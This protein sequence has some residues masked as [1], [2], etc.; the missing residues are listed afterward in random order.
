MVAHTTLSRRTLLA[1]GG[2][3]TAALMTGCSSSL[4]NPPPTSPFVIGPFQTNSV[5]LGE[6][7][8]TQGMPQ[9]FGPGDLPDPVA[10]GNAEGYNRVCE[11]APSNTYEPAPLPVSVKAAV[12]Y[13]TYAGTAQP[14][15]ASNPLHMAPGPFPVLL[16]AHGWR[17]TIEVCNSPIP[18]HRDFTTAQLML[19]HVASYG[20]V[21]IA[22]DLSWL[23]T[24]SLFE[25]SATPDDTAL[26]RAKVLIAYFLYLRDTLNGTLFANQLDLSRI[27][28][29]GHDIGGGAAAAAF[30]LFSLS[31]ITFNSLSCGL[32]APVIVDTTSVSNLLVLYGTLDDPNVTGLDAGSYTHGGTPKTLVKIPG[33]NHWGYTGV[34]T[35][36]NICDAAGV[37]DTQGTIS[38]E[39]QEQTGAAYLAALMRYFAL[40]DGTARPYLT[41]QQQVEGLELYG[42]SGIQI[43]AAGFNTLG[44]TPVSTRGTQP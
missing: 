21:C 19:S 5:I 12:Y 10:L 18:I 37:D 32:I 29:V 17:P 36:D 27:V 13:P 25:G 30:R 9:F 15:T 26:V 1:L 6:S 22:P 3:S 2:L 8:G 14:I 23:P 7:A 41:G 39:G 31:G 42:V 33:A 34:C 20:C 40:G 43:Q 4:T 38:R 11:D 44:P 28:V 16:Y 35:L 24:D